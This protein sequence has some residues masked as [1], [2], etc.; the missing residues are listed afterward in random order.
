MR[1]NSE[2]AAAQYRQEMTV[3]STEEAVV[4]DAEK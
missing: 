3:A 1:L 2:E 4:M